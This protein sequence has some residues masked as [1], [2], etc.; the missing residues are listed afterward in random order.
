MNDSLRWRIFLNSVY[1]LH[2]RLH[3]SETVITEL[4]TTCGFHYEICYLS[5]YSIESIQKKINLTSLYHFS[6]KN[7]VMRLPGRI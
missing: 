2:R 3:Q 6:K 4:L 5:E 7:L 1:F